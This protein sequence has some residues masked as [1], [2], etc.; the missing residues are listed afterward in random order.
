MKKVISLFMVLGLMF[1]F[2]SAASLTDGLV[3]FYPIKAGIE[4]MFSSLHHLQ[5]SH[6]IVYTFFL[7]NK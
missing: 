7:L 5:L 2:G 1:M 6:H 3:A 4:A